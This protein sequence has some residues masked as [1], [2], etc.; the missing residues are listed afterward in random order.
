M[1]VDQIMFTSGSILYGLFTFV[2]E[3]KNKYAI[4]LHN[5]GN[6][7]IVTTFTTSQTRSSICDPVH[8]ANPKEKPRSY[9]FKARTPIGLKDDG[10]VFCFGLDTTVVPDYGYAYSSIDDFKRKVTSLTKVCD[11]YEQEYIDLIYTLYKCSE[12]PKK[13]K[14]VF[15]QILKDKIK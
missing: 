5:D 13:Y 3:S 6:S 7:C 14:T 12:L 10:T 8:G 11:L 1:N 9:V 2:T 15:E 4:V